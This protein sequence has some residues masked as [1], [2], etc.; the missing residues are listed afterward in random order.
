MFCSVDTS[1]DDGLQY[2][3]YLEVLFK[4]QRVGIILFFECGFTYERHH[5]TWYV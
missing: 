5:I 2:G 1:D 4:F 3:S